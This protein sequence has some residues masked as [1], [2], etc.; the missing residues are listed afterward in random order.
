MA[1]E[2]P[3]KAPN[4][5]KDSEEVKDPFPAKAFSNS[6][7]QDQS[8]YCPKLRSWEKKKKKKKTI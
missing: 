2:E 1:D 5:S 4:R 3:S 7:T 6:S 8:N